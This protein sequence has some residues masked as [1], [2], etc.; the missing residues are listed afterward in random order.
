VDSERRRE[1]DDLPREKREREVSWVLREWISLGAESWE[2]RAV[3][4]LAEEAG[5]R[6]E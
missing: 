1:W 3:G 2:L 4:E 5:W 6:D